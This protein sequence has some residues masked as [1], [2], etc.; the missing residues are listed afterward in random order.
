M[1]NWA[2]SLLCGLCFINTVAF[3]S[4]NGNDSNATATANNNADNRSNASVGNV[5]S[6][7]NGGNATAFGGQGGQGGTGLGFGGSSNVDNDVRNTVNTTDVNVN[8]ISNRNSV[9]NRNS[10]RQSQGQIQGQGQSQS[11]RSRSNS[12][13]DQ[14]Q[15]ANNE[16]VNVEGDKV[17]VYSYGH[18]AA[19]AALGTDSI[20]VGT[21]FGGIGFSQTS[22]Y[23]KTDNYI[24]RLIE[25]CKAEVMTKEECSTSYRKAMKRLENRSKSNDRGLLN[26]FGLF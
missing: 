4:N 9:R 17:K 1:R 26:A 22:T 23:A 10:N 20:S 12:D 6:T 16:G 21:I 11:T 3:A 25:A 15:S 24:T 2:I 13:Q 7:S 18:S 14:N 8:D 5:S 19:P